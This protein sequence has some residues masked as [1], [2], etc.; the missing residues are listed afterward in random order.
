MLFIPQARCT[1]IVA[2][3][4]LLSASCE[5]N[6]VSPQPSEYETRAVQI[7][8]LW[9]SATHQIITIGTT[10]GA[11]WSVDPVAGSEQHL[12]DLQPVLG[13]LDGDYFLLEEMNPLDVRSG[14]QLADARG[15]I[16]ASVRAEDLPGYH[17]HLASMVGDKILC[18]SDSSL[19]LY[20]AYSGSSETLLSTRLPPDYIFNPAFAPD[21]DRVAY[22]LSHIDGVDSHSGLWILDLRTRSA[23]L[24]VEGH[25]DFPVWSPDGSHI[26]FA[27]YDGARWQIYVIPA[28][29][30]IPRRISD[31]LRDLNHVWSPSGQRIAYMPDNHVI[32][33]QE[34]SGEGVSAIDTGNLSSG[35][36]VKYCWLSDHQIAYSTGANPGQVL[37][38]D[39]QTSETRILGASKELHL[40]P[41]EDVPGAPQLGIDFRFEIDQA[42]Y[43]VG[44]PV[45]FTFKIVN[46]GPYSVGFLFERYPGLDLEASCGARV[47][48]RPCIVIP[49]EWMFV[50]RPGRTYTMN[51]T[52]PLTDC[53]NTLLPSGDCRL[54]ASLHDGHSPILYRSI[55]LVP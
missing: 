40:Y 8:G 20:Q 12:A 43:R 22:V 5:R 55:R 33:V 27:M 45:L 36:R 25:L 37:I 19:Y 16:L 52:W 29:G 24:L 53:S 54:A 38:N 13:S 3:L 51:Q 34:L 49:D 4:A 42:I 18:Q 47:A 10:D 28:N 7:T 15:L 44:D 23:S 9:F 14:Y 46:N 26:G 50:V 11:A 30:G 41:H 21:G 1:W 35:T 6:P 48:R 31:S 2:G 17:P 32:K 39:L